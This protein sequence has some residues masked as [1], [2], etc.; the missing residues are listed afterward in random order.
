[1]SCAFG[2][3]PGRSKP[4]AIKSSLETQPVKTVM[5]FLKWYRANT[6]KL[7]KNSFVIYPDKFDDAGNITDSTSFYRVDFKGMETYLA[8]LRKSGFI[9]GKYIDAQRNYFQQADSNFKVN[10]AY[11]GPPEGFDADLIMLAQDFDL[12]NLQKSKALLKRKTAKTAEVTILFDYNE[13]KLTYHLTNEQ[14]KWKIDLIED[15]RE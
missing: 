3:Q 11:E 15:S 12:R 9:S 10:H 1:M 5:D 13:L 6:E 2:Q 7:E 4:V 14:G 8:A